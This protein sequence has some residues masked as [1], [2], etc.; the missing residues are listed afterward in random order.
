MDIPN[1]RSSH[2]IPTP[3]GGGVSIVITFNLGL[4]FCA[5]YGVV[6]WAVAI[7]LFF[8]GAIVAVVGFIDDHN[9]INAGVRLFFH[10]LSAAIVV[11]L[12]SGLPILQFFDYAIDFSF[13]GY[14]L[15]GICVVWILN[16]FNFMD[17]IDGIAGVEA[18]TSTLIMGAI[19]FLLFGANDIAI[20]HFILG[21]ASLG[22]LILNFPPAKIF[23]GDAGS[24]FLGLMLAALLLL[25]A[26]ISEGLFWSWL[27]MLGVFIVDATFTLCRRLL[28]G[29]K[30]H[31]AHRCHAYQFA[32]RKYGSHLPVTMAV[33]A[34]NLFW[35]A[36]IAICIS[37]G[38]F[39]GFLGLL[40]AYSLLVFLVIK[41]EAG[42]A[43]KQERLERHV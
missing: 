3:R 31:E 12:S 29:H 33:L 11:Y 13:F 8:S 28:Q 42:N 24:G 9:H 15:A 14:I 39:D 4:L 32:S 26:Q 20:L 7:P 27:V 18:V 5:A 35:L 37:L 1:E 19:S 16:L 34:I 2:S 36:P 25:S 22:F 41:F 43:Q 6:E 30:P 40:I 38:L 23:M 17:G 10:F 21:A